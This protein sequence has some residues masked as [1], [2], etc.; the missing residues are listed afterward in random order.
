MNE[1]LTAW[2]QNTDDA[3][4]RLN[5]EILLFKMPL[6]DGAAAV[7]SQ[8]DGFKENPDNLLRM[9]DL[10]FYG[11]YD[12]AGHFY[13]TDEDAGSWS[14]RD[15]REALRKAIAEQII[16]EADVEYA[17]Q[18][19]GAGMRED[20]KRAGQLAY[21]AYTQWVRTP[22]EQLENA[23]ALTAGALM[24]THTSTVP[25]ILQMMKNG[26]DAAQLAQNIVQESAEAQEQIN[27]IAD[28]MRII[29]NVRNT[30][31]H[32]WHGARR[33]MSALA[34]NDYV[35]VR[36]TRQTAEAAPMSAFALLNLLV[37][38][39]DGDHLSKI[40]RVTYGRKV[41]YAA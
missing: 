20:R 21:R 38:D 29:S 12:G 15:A 34:A 8:W 26:T 25:Q 18:G 4:F 16:T 10:D 7:Y 17:M 11:L 13:C 24:N 2:L 22:E 33:L 35:N 31:D 28:A 23:A 40:S 9:T 27:I 37:D 19:Y 32:P 36:V 1:Q 41:L 30:S 5:A 3:P 14:L 39:T 6:A